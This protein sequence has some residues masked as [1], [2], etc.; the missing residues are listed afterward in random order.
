MKKKLFIAIFVILLPCAAYAATLNV[1]GS[2]GNDSNTYAQV[3][4]G[5]HQWASLDRAVFGST[6]RDTPVTAQ[7][8]QAGDTVIVAAGT[9]VTLSAGHG[10]KYPYFNPVNSG[11]SGNLITFQTDGGAVVLQFPSGAG[12][13]IG[14]YSVDYIKWDGFT[15]D[16]A[17]ALSRPDTGPIVLWDTTGSIIE[18]CVVDGNGDPGYGD[19][20]NGIRLEATINCT[21]RNNLL[22]T[23]TTSG[24]NQRN[25]AGIMAYSNQG[26][27]I[28]NNEI[29]GCGT[30]IYL[31]GESAF[32]QHSY[33]VRYNNIYSNAWGM[34][35]TNF[36]GSQE[37]H[38]SLIY[39]NIVRD[40]TARGISVA[41][42]VSVMNYVTVYNN[43][44]DN[45]L[46]NIG[47][48]YVG[49]GITNLIFR[50]N[51]STNGSELFAAGDT[52]S[53]TGWT[54]DYNLYYAS[55]PYWTYD[56]DGYSSIATWRAAISGDANSS[57]ADPQ[58][59]DRAEKDYRVSV[60]SPALTASS[61]GGPV[62]AYITGSEAI[63]IDGETPDPT[64]SDGIQNGD[65]TGVDCGGSC[66]PCAVPATCETDAT[67]CD[68]E[69]DCSTYWPAYYW[70][71]PVCQ[72]EACETPATSRPTAK[73]VRIKR[74]VVS[75]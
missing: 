16:E 57:V 65:E 5:T 62:G 31:K 1:N 70:C 14:A 74:A 3:A 36:S 55:S 34:Y 38:R 28:E 10:T 20:H 61:T 11:S 21:V 44:I 54:T 32:V 37:S 29:H 39:Q 71:A 51:L 24:V 46:L 63:G 6:D 13:M 18:N 42:D 48:R 58:Y 69:T 59:V 66:D 26:A 67:E 8:A 15:I 41:G 19:N 4:A 64:C 53:L 47:P 49:S 72:A 22:H 7:A 75:P 9:Y 33:T 45:S 60:G 73:G 27:L 2:T 52:N 17:N 12:G 56:G 23:I 68:N 30:G 43:T 50:D 35:V 40:N 25:G